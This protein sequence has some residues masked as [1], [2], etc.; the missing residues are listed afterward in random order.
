MYEIVRRLSEPHVTSTRVMTA[1]LARCCRCGTERR[2]LEQNMRRAN[3]E[4][5]EFCPAC[6][7]ANY[8]HMTDTRI[9]RIWQHMVRRATNPE[10][11]DYKRYGA[12]GR[13]VSSDWLDFKNFYRDMSATY[14]DDLTIDRRDN[15]LGYSK[16]NCRWVTNMVQQSN[17]MNNRTIRFQDK[18]MHLAE[19]CRVAG[20]GRG[21]ISPYLNRG[22]TV[23][24]AL[25]ALASSP[26]KKNRKSRKSTT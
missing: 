14:R 3:R 20:V 26:Y 9:W 16:E 2:L 23:E 6:L 1:I 15:S 5:R 8:H 11:K 4:Q 21:A 12:V 13:G 19:F 7:D 24:G 25:A 17:K 18:N 22:L 10:D